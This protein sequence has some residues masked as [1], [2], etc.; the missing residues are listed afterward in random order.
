MT[1]RGLI[2]RLRQ[3]PEDRLDSEALIF[4]PSAAA[5]G[6]GSLFVVAN[7]VADVKELN[8]NDWGF[9]NEHPVLLAEN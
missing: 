4:V 9:D 1:Y 5:E 7:E 3:I 6:G 8:L 2:A